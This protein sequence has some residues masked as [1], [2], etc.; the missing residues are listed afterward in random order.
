MIVNEVCDVCGVV[1][2]FLKR[3]WVMV[4]QSRFKE[5]WFGGGGVLEVAFRLPCARIVLA[6]TDSSNPS[7]PTKTHHIN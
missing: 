3:P 6:A 7:Q 5:F 4:L 1:V 2:L